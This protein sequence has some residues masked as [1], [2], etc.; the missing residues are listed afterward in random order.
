MA[1]K[2]PVAAISRVHPSSVD[3][4]R[5]S[6]AGFVAQDFVHLVVPDGLDP[7]GLHPGEQLVLHDLLRA[8]PVSAVDQIDLAG[9]IG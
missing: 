6:G 9:E 2:Q 4:P 7:A 5:A 3:Q 8:Q 1:T